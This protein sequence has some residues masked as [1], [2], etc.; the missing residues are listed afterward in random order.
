MH[1]SR[2]FVPLL[3][4]GLLQGGAMVSAAAQRPVSSPTD[5]TRRA[6][7][8]FAMYAAAGRPGCA[9]DLRRGRDSLLTR[10]WGEAEL[11]HGIPITPATV[12]E[13]GSVSKQVTAAAV[14]L[15]A[16]RGVLSLDDP[17]QRWFPEMPVYEAPITVRHLILHT[18][19][20]RDWGAVA[21]LEGW[22]RGTR[23]HRQEHALAIASRQRGLNHAPGA[24]FS[25]TNTGYNLLAL[26][27]GR[28]SGLPFA[29]FTRREF[30]APLAMTST[31]WRDDPSR[32]VRGRAQAYTRSFSGAWQLAMPFEHVHGNGGLLTTVAD[33]HRWTDALVAGRLGSPD[34]SGR[35]RTEGTLRDGGGAGYGGGLFLGDVYGVPAVYHTGATG[36][37]RAFLAYFPD[38]DVRAAVLCNAADAVPQLLARRVLD[39]MLPFASSTNA[40][41]APA[42]PR[43][44]ADPARFGDYAG[45]YVSDEAAARW[46]IT[47]DSGRVRL[48]RGPGDGA[49]LAALARDAFT[50]PGGMRLEF[51]RDDAGRV[52]ALS[53]SV[54]RALGVRFVRE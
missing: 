52:H 36:G 39:E 41:A 4:A 15:L 6:D 35:M 20:L 51:L 17:I 26:L 48:S 46:T 22:P 16:E 10:A 8:V 29:E 1:R 9:L 33:L 13:A 14:L 3:A 50:G 2:L 49:P 11:E 18:S 21:G 30:F 25:Y 40:P 44:P 47:A 43:E 42:A 34:V 31:S 28:A 37:Y 12:F 23:D 45:V 24:A 19:G 54:S 53:V 32:L 27:V 38:S 5:L 7:S